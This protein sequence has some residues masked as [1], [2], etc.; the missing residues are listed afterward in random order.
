MEFKGQ[1]K[2]NK[3]TYVTFEGMEQ[4]SKDVED[5]S[6]DAIKAVTCLAKKHGCLEYT[7]LIQLIEFLITREK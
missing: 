4:A 6:N 7:F 5:L 2:N 1:K 3:T